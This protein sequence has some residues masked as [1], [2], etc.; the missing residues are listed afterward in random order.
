VKQRILELDD[1]VNRF[2]QQ[3]IGKLIND[4]AEVRGLL[5]QFDAER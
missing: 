4:N 5:G 1:V 2:S 3:R